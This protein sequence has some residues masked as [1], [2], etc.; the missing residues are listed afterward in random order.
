MAVSILFWVLAAIASATENLH[1]FYKLQVAMWSE[2]LT[3]LERAWARMAI[4]LATG[5]IP[6][7]RH[8]RR[9]GYLRDVEDE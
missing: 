4:R 9:N 3:R 6:R 7:A 5:Y 8:W 1:Q 2:A